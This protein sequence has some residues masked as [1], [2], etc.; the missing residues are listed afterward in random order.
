MLL[1]KAGFQDAIVFSLSKIDSGN[2]H[3][4][5]IVGPGS[6]IYLDS[7]GDWSLQ[8]KRE[9]IL[10]ESDDQARNKCKRETNKISCV[11][12]MSSSCMPSGV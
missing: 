5:N 2:S 9:A 10:M 4:D 7:L 12:F 3:P 8:K 11:P 6:L 1:H